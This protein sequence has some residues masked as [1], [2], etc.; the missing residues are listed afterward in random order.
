MIYCLKEIRSCRNQI[1]GSLRR[2]V[3]GKDEDSAAQRLQS[4]FWV[5]TVRKPKLVF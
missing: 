4:Y 1:V 5:A 2:R 3:R